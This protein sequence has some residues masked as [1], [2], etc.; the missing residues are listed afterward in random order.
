MAHTGLN[1]TTRCWGTALQAVTYWL[2]EDQEE[3]MFVFLNNQTKTTK[4]GSLYFSQ[5]E[6][7]PCD[8]IRI[9]AG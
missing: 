2:R 6:A 5:T 8:V 9:T 3:D 1:T 4:K 7:V